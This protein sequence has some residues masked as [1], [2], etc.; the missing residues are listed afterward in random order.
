M[1]SAYLACVLCT[2]PASEK[3]QATWLH[4]NMCTTAR[5]LSQNPNIKALK[6]WGFINQRSTLG[7]SSA[8]FQDLGLGLEDLGRVVLAG[9]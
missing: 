2:A 4:I 8:R 3:A 6:R 9:G 1:P 5:V 7:V